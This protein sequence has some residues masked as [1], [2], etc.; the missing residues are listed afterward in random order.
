MASS[1]KLLSLNCRMSPIL[2]RILTIKIIEFVDTTF[3][4]T[5]NFL[6]RV[7]RTIVVHKCVFYLF[8]D[9]MR[10]ILNQYSLLNGIT[11]RPVLRK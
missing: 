7:Q 1:R 3:G 2:T 8:G 11:G 10:E 9:K 4:N 6:F 5:T